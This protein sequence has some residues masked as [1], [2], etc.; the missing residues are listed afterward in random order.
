MKKV[1]RVRQKI[2]RKAFC[3]TTCCRRTCL[4]KE[5]KRIEWRHKRT[6]NGI[7]KWLFHVFNTTFLTNN[8][9]EKFVR[10]KNLNKDYLTNNHSF[11]PVNEEVELDENN[12]FVSPGQ[13][14]MLQ[15]EPDELQQSTLG[16]ADFICFYRSCNQSESYS[17]FHSRGE[18]LDGE[19]Q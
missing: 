18:W 7:E 19:Y 10:Q 4:R 11:V 15:D 3:R 17:K 14:P 9:S 16:K 13:L 1:K 12:S 2:I 8:F 5:R 6:A